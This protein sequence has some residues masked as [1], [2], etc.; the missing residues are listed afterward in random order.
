MPL[1]R[2][3]APHSGKLWGCFDPFSK[4]AAFGLPVIGSVFSCI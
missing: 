4:I 2:H 1:R 3:L